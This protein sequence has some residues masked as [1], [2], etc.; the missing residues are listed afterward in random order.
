MSYA[1]LKFPLKVEYEITSRCNFNCIHC[2]SKTNR[3]GNELSYTEIRELIDQLVDENTVEMQFTGGE[4][5]IREDLVEHIRYAN[6]K[7]LKVLVSSNGSLITDSISK[8]LA[9]CSKCTVEISIDGPEEIHN[10]IRGNNNAYHLAIRGI[11]TLKKFNNRVM[12]ESVINNINIK[13]IPYV[14]NLAQELGVYRYIIHNTRFLGNAKNNIEKLY[15]IKEELEAVQRFIE[16][17]RKETKMQLQSPYL[18]IYNYSKLVGQVGKRRYFGCGASIYK[19]GIKE[20]GTI[21]PCLL[22]DE[23][24]KNIRNT[25][26]REAWNSQYFKAIREL[27]NLRSEGCDNC[28]S[29]D[30]CNKGCCLVSLD[31]SGSFLGEDISCPIKFTR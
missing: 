31:N 5:F 24:T 22:F 26:I 9:K 23:G 2:M 14:Y 17:K 30:I 11:K 10:K 21:V 20:D 13:H 18:P 4:P 12:I 25:T 3:N 15:P 8:E 28:E 16:E 6:E 1:T 27:I 29:R 7:G 19:C